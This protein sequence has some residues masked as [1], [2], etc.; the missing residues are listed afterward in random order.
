M[1]WNEHAIAIMA[2]K[3]EQQST[4]GRALPQRPFKAQARIKALVELL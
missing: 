2:S 4:A 3:P 1:V